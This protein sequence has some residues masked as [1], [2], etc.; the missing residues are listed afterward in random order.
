M[1]QAVSNMLFECGGLRAGAR[2]LIVHE[3]PGTGYYDDAM[4]PSLAQ[5]AATLGLQVRL[6]QVDFSPDPARPDDLC[7]AMQAHDLTVFVA[8]IGDQLRF[9]ED[10]FG[11]PS[12]V[13]YALDPQSFASSF[14]TLEYGGMQALC[15]AIDD[16]LAQA[17]E[18]RITCPDGTDL[19]GQVSQRTAGQDTETLRFP[20]LVHA[21]VP[22]AG[23]SGHVVQT[24]FLVGTGAR[25]YHPYALELDS[26]LTFEIEGNRICA[27][28]GRNAAAARA[29]YNAVADRFGIDP[30]FVHSWHAGIHPGCAFDAPV[31]ASFER[32]SGAAFGSP[33]LLHLHTC[34]AYAPGEISLNLL[35]ATIE[36]D[37]HA[38]WF[39]GRL[40]PASA[41]R[42]A[43]VMR[44]WPSL[45]SAF[46]QPELTCGLV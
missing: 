1:K 4:A 2:V 28:T 11:A 14:G 32:W 39:N 46:Q 13:C 45:Y 9:V 24:R 25:Y 33:R 18:I 8:R 15:Q 12:V 16:A 40:L 21:P 3:P 31:S 26:P 5:A 37:G 23:F 6:F 30:W 17:H 7:R 22:A 34:G 19:R 41:P 43:E 44:Q 42:G 29:H 20:K 36:L 27:I 38:L 35:D 10:A